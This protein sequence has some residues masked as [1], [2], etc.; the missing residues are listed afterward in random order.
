MDTGT[1]FLTE[2]IGFNFPG[3]AVIVRVTNSVNFESAGFDQKTVVLI[4]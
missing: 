3:G 4:Y 1:C 2:K